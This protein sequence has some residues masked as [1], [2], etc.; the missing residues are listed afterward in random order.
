MD[1]RF[2]DILK[3]INPEILENENADL[4]DDGLLD[5]LLIMNLVSKLESTFGIEFEPDE[6]A[7]ENFESVDAIWNLV[8]QHMGED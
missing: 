2:W 5:S 6:I 4:L 1:K 8:R 7:P 3:Q